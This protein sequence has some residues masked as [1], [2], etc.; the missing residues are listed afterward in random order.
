MSCVQNGAGHPL[1]PEDVPR[2]AHVFGGLTSC[3]LGMAEVL[4]LLAV[5]A[6]GR[7]CTDYHI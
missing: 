7:L 2:R 5:I 6:A 4:H 1:L 3:V